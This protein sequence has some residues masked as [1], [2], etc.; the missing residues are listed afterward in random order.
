MS[1]KLQNKSHHSYNM[2][3][4]LSF[5]YAVKI[6]SYLFCLLII[7]L[8]LFIMFTVISLLH[9]FHWITLVLPY[10]ILNLSRKVPSTWMAKKFIVNEQI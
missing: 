1:V 2:T 8:V 3:C 6:C 9:K 10:F 7:V 5:S 4:V